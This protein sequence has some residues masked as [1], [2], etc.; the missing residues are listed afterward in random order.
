MFSKLYLSCCYRCG[1]W[2]L[3]VE[4]GF[5]CRFVIWGRRYKKEQ[6]F[7]P[8]MTQFAFEWRINLSHFI[9]LII[10]LTKDR[11]DAAVPTVSVV[12]I[13]YLIIIIDCFLTENIL[14]CL[15]GWEKLREWERILKESAIIYC[16]TFYHYHYWY[17]SKQNK[18]L[19]FVQLMSQRDMKRVSTE[20]KPRHFNLHRPTD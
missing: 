3:V 11:F 19:K 6:V 20:C 10:S 13:E 8:R 17:N 15:M 7:N 12:S 1:R 16:N 2:L 18:I 9:S 4:F 14:E 5:F